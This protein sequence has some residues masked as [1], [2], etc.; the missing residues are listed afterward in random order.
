MLLYLNEYLSIIGRLEVKN[1]QLVMK[2]SSFQKLEVLIMGTSLMVQW[3]RLLMQGA[4]GSIPGQGTIS[5][6]A[7]LRVCIS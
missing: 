5:H 4:P 3:L 7:Q 6:M 1:F 2:Y